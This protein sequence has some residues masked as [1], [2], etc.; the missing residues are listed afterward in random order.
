MCTRLHFVIELVKGSYSLVSSPDFQES[1]MYQ[2]CT[3]TSSLTK[4]SNQVYVDREPRNT[5]AS[6]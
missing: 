5:N 2:I 6:L 1:E 4:Y 3:K